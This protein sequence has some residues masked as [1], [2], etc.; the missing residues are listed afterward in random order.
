MEIIYMAFA[1]FQVMY[2]MYSPA[3]HRMLREQ[4]YRYVIHGEEI[5]KEVL[6]AE[7]QRAELNVE[8]TPTRQQ[9]AAEHFYQL[10]SP[11]GVDMCGGAYNV[12]FWIGGAYLHELETKYN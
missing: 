9:P 6:T 8:L 12:L 5:G 11:E 1:Y 4:G 3:I 10:D 7:A 2:R